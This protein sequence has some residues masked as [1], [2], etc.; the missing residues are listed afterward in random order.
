MR[1]Y[2]FHGVCFCLLR[3]GLM[4]VTPLCNSTVVGSNPVVEYS[5]AILAEWGIPQL[6]IHRLGV[7]IPAMHIFLFKTF[8]CIIPV[9]SNG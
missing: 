5:R 8:L 4:V 7:Q 1:L 9:L 6:S 3:C 2:L